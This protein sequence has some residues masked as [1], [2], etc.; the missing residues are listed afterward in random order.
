VWRDEDIRVMEFVLEIDLVCLRDKTYHEVFSS[1]AGRTTFTSKV[2]K[3][4]IDA[5]SFYC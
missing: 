3:K 1:Q 2:S 5:R 4:T